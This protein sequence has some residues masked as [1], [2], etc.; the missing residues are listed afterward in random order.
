M[1]NKKYYINSAGESVEISTLETTHLTNALA[2]KYRELF[3]S[4]SKEDYSRRLNEINDLKE[5][6]YGRFNS[7]YE[8]LD[9]ADEV[10]NG[11]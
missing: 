6:L 8:K 3:E 5:D 10:S 4:T 2:K 1:E 7:F 11:K 9:K